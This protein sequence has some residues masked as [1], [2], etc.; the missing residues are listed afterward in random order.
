MLFLAGIPIFFLETAIGQFSGLSPTHAFA[1][2]VPVFQGLGY[3]AIIINA[4]V[5]F[6]YNII[7][8]HCLYYFI[9]SIRAELPWAKCIDNFKNCFQCNATLV[10]EFNTSC[11]IQRVQFALLTNISS[12]NI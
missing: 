9:F 2:M 7:I 10:K 8:A 4:F 11:S 6:F 12:K 3:A 1:N 5:G